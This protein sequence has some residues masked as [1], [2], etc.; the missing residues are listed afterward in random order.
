MWDI[1][2]SATEATRSAVGLGIEVR[3]L[4]YSPDGG[5]LV[6]AGYG[7]V[8]GLFDAATGARAHRNV[9]GANRGLHGVHR[10]RA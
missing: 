5:R 4:L 6:A 10:I 8:A 9:G 2:T 7:R 1:A 3:D